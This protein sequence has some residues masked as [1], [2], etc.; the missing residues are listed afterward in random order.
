MSLD[1]NYVKLCQEIES[2]KG[3]LLDDY[4]FYLE[5]NIGHTDEQKRTIFLNK[6]KKEKEFMK[7][8]SILEKFE[9]CKRY[10]SKIDLPPVSESTENNR[11]IKRS[12]KK[13]RRGP[14]PLIYY[15]INGVKNETIHKIRPLK[16]LTE[17]LGREKFLEIVDNN[18]FKYRTRFQRSYEETNEN[19]G[20]IENSNKKTYGTKFP[21]INRLVCLCTEDILKVIQEILPKTDLSMTISID[22]KDVLDYHHS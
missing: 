22:G 16:T 1:Q 2:K 13:A 3:E 21:L 4:S 17:I 12:K 6:D 7:L 15:T 9:E 8:N 19:N 20:L 14:K 10:S 11:K 18:S 5:N